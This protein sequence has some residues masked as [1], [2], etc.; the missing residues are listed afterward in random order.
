MIA[1]QQNSARAARTKDTVGSYCSAFIA[2]SLHRSHKF[3]Q[4]VLFFWQWLRGETAENERD[5][6]RKINRN[7]WQMKSHVVQGLSPHN[8]FF[9]LGCDLI[10]YVQTQ[11]CWYDK[12]HLFDNTVPF[13]IFLIF[14]LPFPSALFVIDFRDIFFIGWFRDSSRLV[15]PRES[16]F[17][18]PGKVGMNRPFPLKSGDP[19]I[20]F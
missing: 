2:F 5:L 19:R 1:G 10:M 18:I 9:N 8:T 16:H 14:G 7:P 11:I 13:L 17:A 4:E 6:E 3:L 15:F 12:P 20:D